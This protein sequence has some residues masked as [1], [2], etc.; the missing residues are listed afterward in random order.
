MKE[1]ILKALK[2]RYEGD[3][4]AAKANVEVYLSQAVGIGEHADII[5]AVDSQVCLIVEAQEKLLFIEESLKG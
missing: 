4:A 2:A 1:I 3:I 5:S